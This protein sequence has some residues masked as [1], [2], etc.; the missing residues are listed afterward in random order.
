MFVIVR[1]KNARKP[2]HVTA[3]WVWQDQAGIQ[4]G[5]LKP[6]EGHEKGP[7]VGRQMQSGRNSL[8]PKGGVNSGLVKYVFVLEMVIAH[9]YEP[10]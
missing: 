10:G 6:L 2:S 4:R 9:H 7:G 1:C 3:G 8:R 5:A